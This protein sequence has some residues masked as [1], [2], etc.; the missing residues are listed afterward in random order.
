MSQA[1]TLQSSVMT[2]A[3]ELFRE[4]GIRTMKAWSEALRRA[5]DIVKS[6]YKKEETQLDLDKMSIDELENLLQAVKAKLEEKKAAQLKEFTFS[7]NHTNDTRKGKPYAARLY[8][9]E[10]GK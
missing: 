3:W 6:S 5:W 1:Y 10:N 9:D 4:A 2:K 7:F 8:L